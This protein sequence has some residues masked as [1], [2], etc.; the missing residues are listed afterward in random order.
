MKTLH[1]PRREPQAG[2]W[3]FFLASLGL[4]LGSAAG[5]SAGSLALPAWS[6]EG[7]LDSISSAISG[8]RLVQVGVIGMCLALFFI[9]RGK[10]K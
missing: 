5:S 4:P 10:W 8:D 6:L 2:T 1:T 9:T 7:I 3:P